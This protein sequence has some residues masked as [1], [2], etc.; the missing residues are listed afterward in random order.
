MIVYNLATDLDNPILATA[1]LWL[2]G[3]EDQG[4]AL[5]VY[6]TYVGR[7]NLSET[8][9]IVEIG[10]GNLFHRLRA[11]YR[12]T[13]SLKI[14]IKQRKKIIVL[15][16][17]SPRTAIFPG[18]L[19]KVLGI[20]QGLWYSHSKTPLSIRIA[21][22][23]VDEIFTST[24]TSFPLPTS[25]L[26]CIGHGI[27]TDVFIESAKPRNRSQIGYLGRVA[28]IKRLEALIYA[29][30]KT[31]GNFE[32]IATGTSDEGGKYKDSLTNLAVRHQVKIQINNEISHEL[33][34]DHL[35]KFYFVYSGMMNSVDKSAIEAAVNGCFVVTLDKDTQELTGMSKI[36]NVLNIHTNLNLEKQLNVLKS[37]TEE[38]ETYWR[39]KVAEDARNKNNYLKL[40]ENIS[41]T[42]KLRLK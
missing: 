25:K 7:N 11:I 40:T 22:R 16:H 8:T 20:P 3:F 5:N 2:K 15:H 24:R 38:E 31:P 12:L 29:V 27:N 23:V 37:F 42:L 41:N 36:W 13:G 33:V 4:H 14:L 39:I 6:S 19:I 21:T 9:K 32:I 1:H 30:S 18:V 26:N 10:G 17:M 28:P 35:S 34:N